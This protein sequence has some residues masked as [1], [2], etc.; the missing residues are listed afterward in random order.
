MK[1]FEERIILSEA[2]GK[3]SGLKQSIIYYMFSLNYTQQETADLLGLNQRK[4][5]RLLK[6]SL[7]ELKGYL[8]E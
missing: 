4:V 2:I 3:L 7:T 8:L 5:S 1:V 6:S